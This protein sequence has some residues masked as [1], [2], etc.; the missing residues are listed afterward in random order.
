MY[1]IKNSFISNINTEMIRKRS[2][3]TIITMFALA[4][5]MCLPQISGSCMR[6]NPDVAIDGKV[7]GRL[8]EFL[9]QQVGR[10]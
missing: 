8:S 6:S 5:I 1:K 7:A 10:R 9:T 4:L 3:R 2:A